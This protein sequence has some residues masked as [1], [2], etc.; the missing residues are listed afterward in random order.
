MPQ[1]K[2]QS[3]SRSGRKATTPRK[4]KTTPHVPAWNS[5]DTEGGPL[6]RELLTIK[7]VRLVDIIERGGRIVFTQASGFS[8]LE[9]RV[10][11]WACETPPLSV[12]DL[13]ARVHRGAAQVSRTVQKLVN[14]KLLHR[15]NR[16]GGPGVSIKATPLGVSVYGPLVALARQRDAE[17]IKGLSEADQRTMERCVAT[18]TDNALKQLARLQGA[19]V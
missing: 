4:R 17:M 16:A 6:S 12:N 1:V 15:T 8:D 19:E 13:A 14:A 10:L 3:G 2:L 5:R 18:M 7:I 9:W 11:A